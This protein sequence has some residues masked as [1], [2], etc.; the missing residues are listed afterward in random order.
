MDREIVGA[1]GEE[2]FGR[3]ESTVVEDC[4]DSSGEE[5]CKLGEEGGCLV[6]GKGWHGGFELAAMVR[7][8]RAGRVRL[9]TWW[10]G[11]DTREH[12]M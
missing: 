4:M 8:R 9:G 1:G 3:V 2:G 10:G 12:V 7:V 11:V 6:E 5:D